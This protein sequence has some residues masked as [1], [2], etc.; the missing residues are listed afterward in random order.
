V[1]PDL[2]SAGP[3]P[4]PG[5]RWT[6]V[7]HGE[8]EP[9][10]HPGD[11]DVPLNPRGLEQAEEV[12][13]R[14]AAFAPYDALVTSPFA[15][16]RQTASPSAAAFGLAPV[17]DRGLREFLMAPEGAADEEA[18]GRAWALAREHWDEAPPEGESVVQFHA[19]VAAALD[20]LAAAHPGEHLLGFCHGG[21]IKM[22]FLHFLELP[23]ARAT[24]LP[25]QIDHV[26]VFRF[27][28]VEGPGGLS[29]KLLGAN[30]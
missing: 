27:E 11:E 25:L 29:W 22:A 17:A 14:L 2:E 4:V 1:S 30:L 19:R 18:M 16:A 10:R 6:L 21:V 20:R 28:R 15:R 13:A 8:Q 23:L 7:R 3:A 26:G 9:P 12:V 24:R 5:T